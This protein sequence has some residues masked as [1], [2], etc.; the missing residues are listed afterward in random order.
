MNLV[1]LLIAPLV[2]SFADDVA[3]RITIAAVGAVILGL[4]IWHSK[5][6]RGP[7][8]ISSD[9]PSPEAATVTTETG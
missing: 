3:M 6:Q 5:R 1:A 7:E 8:L 9:P 4:A 2:V